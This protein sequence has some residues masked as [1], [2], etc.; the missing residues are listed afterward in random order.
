M[1]SQRENPLRG[2]AGI[3]NLLLSLYLCASTEGR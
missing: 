2:G 3:M 1:S